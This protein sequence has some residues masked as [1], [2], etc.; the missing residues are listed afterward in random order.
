[1]KQPLWQR[2]RRGQGPNDVDPPADESPQPVDADSAPAPRAPADIRSRL[3]DLG[4]TRPAPTE[5]P[6]DRLGGDLAE[7]DSPDRQAAYAAW[8]DRMRS[9]KKD[10]LADITAEQAAA[11]EA[12]TRTPISPYW[13]S[14]TLFAPPES[15]NPT[16]PALMETSA[17]L[18]ILEVSGE[19][20]DEELTAAFRKLAKVHHPDRWHDAAAEVR[21]EHEERMALITEAHRELR[22]RRS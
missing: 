18:A 13:D 14:S 16:D 8:A 19:V 6:D 5:P 15:E 7:D 4:T 9:H 2:R 3:R 10:K 11:A 21:L 1:V 22:R 17:L 12:E 20:S